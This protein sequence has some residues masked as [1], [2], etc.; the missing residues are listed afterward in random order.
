MNK[1]TRKQFSKQNPRLPSFYTAKC[2]PM[3]LSTA[4][5]QSSQAYQRPV[6][7][8]HVKDI[9]E[10]FNPLYLDE[11]IVS[12]RDH[13][14]YVIDGQNRI[15]ALKLMNGGNDC[16]VNCKVYRGLSYEQEADMFYHLDC[17]KK[18]LRYNDTVRAKAEAKTDPVVVDINRILSEYGIRWVY[19]GNTTT[20]TV[21][22]SR[23]LVSKYEQLGPYVFELVIRLL[24]RTWNGH[25]ESMTAA[26]IEGL[27]L[28]VKVYVHEAQEDIFVK[29]L[30]IVT[31]AEIKFLARAE[32][33]ASKNEL[34]YARVF[35][36]KYN[37][38]TSGSAKLEYRLG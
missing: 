9:V 20:G 7:P 10:N 12:Y 38:R 2:I 17:I 24:V 30:S 36:S 21:R 3:Q 32:V 37:H 25:R 16:M 1:S 27:A 22:A 5:L 4:A 35:F 31:P 28:F 6:D 15:A 26:F 19:V 14:Y 23:T 13:T 33:S 29:K 34:K 18:R 11:I 8:T